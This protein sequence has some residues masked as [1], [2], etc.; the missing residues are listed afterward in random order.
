MGSREFAAIASVRAERRRRFGLTLLFIAP[1]SMG[2][3]MAMPSHDWFRWVFAV[4]GMIYAAWGVWQIN[5]SDL[6]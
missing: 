6:D 2:C 3:A 4:V 1:V 5:R